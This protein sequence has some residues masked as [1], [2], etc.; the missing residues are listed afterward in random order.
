MAGRREPPRLREV[1]LAVV[2]GVLGAS[3]V[4]GVPG[5]LARWTV[6][7]PQPRSD[8]PPWEPP[9]FHL[10]FTV[11]P[12]LSAETDY[13]M[14]ADILR[15]EGVRDLPVT[16]ALRLPRPEFFRDAVLSPG[17]DRV[18]L[19]VQPPEALER[20]EPG[21]G[22]SA[23]RTWTT[24]FEVEFRDAEDRP[25]GTVGETVFVARMGR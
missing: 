21:D 18:A 2:A 7:G 13:R 22:P 5:M 15:R 14:E 19:R 1:A 24:I 20:I 12:G 17:C 8:A 11:G 25:V 9:P 10:R 4:L 3:V 23:I 6:G 16:C